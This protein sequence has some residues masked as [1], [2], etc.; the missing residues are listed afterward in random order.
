MVLTAHTPVRGEHLRNFRFAIFGAMLHHSYDLG[1][2]GV[3]HKVHG[4]PN[5]Q[6]LRMLL[7]RTWNR[8]AMRKGDLLT[9]Q[10]LP[11]IMELA[12]SPA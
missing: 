10:Y 5:T 6:Y 7:L 2:V 11:G 1:L 4:T 8:R 12:M 3:R 9:L